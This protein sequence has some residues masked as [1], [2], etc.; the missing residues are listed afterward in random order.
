MTLVQHEDTKERVMRGL[1]VMAM[2]VVSLAQADSKDYT[3]VRDLALE[4]AGLAEFVIDTGAGALVVTGVDGADAIAVTAT[5]VIDAKNGEEAQKLIAKH[6]DLK[7]ER[8][9]DRAILQS[10]FD[11]GWGWDGNARIDLDIRMPA[12]LALLVDDG[13]GSTIITDV[14]ADVLVDDGSGS[15]VITNAGSVTVDDGSGSIRIS[16]AS[17]DVYVNDGSGTID[18]RGVGGSVRIDDGSGSIRV[19]DVENDLVIVDDGSGGLT[20]TNVRGAV[21]QDD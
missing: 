12:G 10:G 8:D 9:G 20:Y 3:E 17:G 18:I 2:F 5:I 16:A 21:Q 13:S 14:K 15:V 1:I 7:L 11:S 19:D 4:T 6:L